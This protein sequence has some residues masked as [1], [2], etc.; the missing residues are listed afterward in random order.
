MPAMLLR[1][2]HWHLSVCQ[3]RLLLARGVRADSMRTCVVL[4]IYEWSRVQAAARAL[5]V[6]QSSQ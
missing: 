6:V 4:Q 2:L 5:A 3:R 1:R